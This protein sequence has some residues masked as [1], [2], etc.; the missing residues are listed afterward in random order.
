[1]SE[2]AKSAHNGSLIDGIKKFFTSRVGKLLILL[3]IILAIPLTVFIGG[4]QQETRQRAAAPAGVRDCDNSKVSMTVSPSTIRMGDKFNLTFRSL[5]QSEGTLFIKNT[6]SGT[7]DV[8]NC[9][10]PLGATSTAVCDTKTQGTVTW[11]HQWRNCKDGSASICQQY[12]PDDNLTPIQNLISDQCSATTTFT[13]GPALPNQPTTVI[14]AATISGPTEGIVGVPFD[15]GSF[16]ASINAGTGKT[17]L[18]SGMVVTKISNSTNNISANTF[19]LSPGQTQFDC[20]PNNQPPN[21]FIG[22]SGNYNS[23]YCFIAP[24]QNGQQ[25][26]TLVSEEWTPSE[27]GTYL[28]IVDVINQDGKCSGKPYILDTAGGDD[29]RCDPTTNHDFIKVVVNAGPTA[30]IQINGGSS[31]ITDRTLTG[32]VGTA[33]PADKFK[34][35]VNAAP[36]A[37]LLWN[38]I[39]IVKVDNNNNPVPPAD[40]TN[41][42]E[43][44]PPNAIAEVTDNPN[45]L[46]NGRYCAID[47]SAAATGTTGTL[48]SNAW[49][50]TEEGKYLVIVDNLQ[51]TPSGLV[52]KC[53]GSPYGSDT[54]LRCDSQNYDY[55][56]LTVGPPA[57][58][59]TN[60]PGPTTT[61]TNTPTGTRTPTPSPTTITY[62]PADFN[63]S[64]CV[65]KKDYDVWFAAYTNKAVQGGTFPNVVTRPGEN[66]DLRD[67]NFWYNAMIT[68]PT[69]TGT[70]LCAL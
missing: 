68:L 11:T 55:L 61:P 24:A 20:P 70:L 43:C 64:T 1:M 32:I 16:R 38:A 33:I 40:P 2:T 9:T 65:N 18:A 47:K 27:S 36:G 3:V 63:H 53:S 69:G 39:W 17:I 15:P 48:F 13:I 23:R 7:G 22:G 50:P 51:K 66:V 8:T 52:S 45:P 57:P 62:H 10:F 4:Q 29:G 5:D 37:T 6:F 41:R 42:Y 54:P 59:A 30:R 21:L 58:T 46:L 35:T 44:S 28:V 14:P 25:Q 67:F 19:P 34:A 49:T 26:A 31:S 12:G 56:T 60:T